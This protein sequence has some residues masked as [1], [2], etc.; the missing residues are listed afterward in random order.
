MSSLV[1]NYKIVF[2]VVLQL[3]KW[4]FWWKGDSLNFYQ[5][6]LSLKDQSVQVAEVA[7]S[8]VRM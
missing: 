4:A 6:S 2:A 7:V 8:W 3:C 1:L 5:F